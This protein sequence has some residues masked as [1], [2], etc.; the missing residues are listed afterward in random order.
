MPITPQAG[1][2]VDPANPNGVIKAPDMS[3]SP[4]NAGSAQVLANQAAAAKLGVQIPGVGGV[5]TTSTPTTLSG[6]KT[7]TIADN[8]SKVQ[9]M[10]NSPNGNVT[11]Q[12]AYER[13]SN[14][15][16]ANAPSDAVAT[17]DENGRTT[18]TSGGRNYYLAPDTPEYASPE[19]TKSRDLLDQIKSQTDAAFA[20][21]ISSIKAQYDS[22]LKEQADVNTRQNASV[23]Q[24]LLMGGTSRYAQMNAGGISTAQM[25]Y[26]IQKIADL[27]AK[28]NAAIATVISAQADADYQIVGKQLDRLKDIKAEKQAAANK[29]NDALTAQAEKIKTQQEQASKDSAISQQIS[30]GIT[31]PNTILKNLRA[32][33]DT[34][35]NISDIADAIKN[36]NPNAAEIVNIL[37]EAGKNGASSEVLAKI[38]KATNLSDAISLAG[39]YLQDATSTAGQYTTYLNNLPEGKKPMSAGDFIAAQKYK[40]AYNAE[41]AKNAFVSSSGNQSKLE[42]QYR[43]VLLKE[44]SNRSGGLGLQDA[45]VNQA[46]H[47]KALV[48]QY[49]DDKGNYNIPQVQYAE[50][51]MGLASLLSG[52]N[53]VSDSARESITQKTLSGDINGAISYITGAPQTGS[54]QDTFKNLIDSIDRQGMVAEDLRDSYVGTLHGF[55]PTDLEPSRV[56]ALEKNTLPSY[57]NPPI[58]HQTPEQIINTADAAVSSFGKVSPENDA[59]VR[60]LFTAFPNASSVDIYQKLK[61]KGFI[62]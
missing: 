27:Q 43:T 8:T 44:L 56:Q 15:D 26:G 1:Y 13:Y 60:Q 40:E 12:D 29:L 25:S 7:Q 42:Q 39:G 20:G 5:N 30:N 19:D 16:W 57:R 53:T 41:A 45:K 22:L 18:Y 61:D 35:T 9:T 46:I 48:E 3:A 49:K 47:L 23:D 4:A 59:R 52:T 11:G 37:K 21:Q 6:D 10:Q 32:N 34:K 14:G 17:L 24:T 50:L 28:E 31:D 55:A 2:I 58:S 36:L 33:G 62:Q 38:G 51:A 54:T